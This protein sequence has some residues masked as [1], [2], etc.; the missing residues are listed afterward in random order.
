MDSFLTEN[1]DFTYFNDQIQKDLPG[2]IIGVEIPFD[3][4]STPLATC[5]IPQRGSFISKITLKMQLTTSPT[6]ASDYT[7]YSNTISGT[8]YAVT[9]S[10]TSAPFNVLPNVYSISNASTWIAPWFS[11]TSTNFTSNI[12]YGPISYIVFSSVALANFYGQVDN[13]TPMYGGYVKFSSISST[14]TYQQ[15]GWLP[16]TGI[17]ATPSTNNLFGNAYFLVSGQVIQQFS[18]DYIDKKVP[19]SMNYTNVPILPLLHGDSNPIVDARVYYYRLPFI[20]R[21]PLGKAP[22]QVYIDRGTVPTKMSLLVEYIQTANTAPTCDLIIN[23]I[24]T[25]GPVHQ[26]IGAVSGYLNNEKLFGSDE[27]NVAAFDNLFNP[28]AATVPWY[29][30]NNPIN[31]SRI[32]TPIITGTYIE[33]LNVLTIQD[34]LAGLRFN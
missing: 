28:G 10:G 14:Y 22:F 3:N 2:K 7:F 20:E 27:T 8:M 17:Y 15:T 1:P 13:A 32:A 16:G 5:T 33:T 12:S 23:Q 21:I 30:F 18:K 29:V 11:A 19:V 26:V 6:I 4:Q 9:A 25:K 24:S 34:S 31:L